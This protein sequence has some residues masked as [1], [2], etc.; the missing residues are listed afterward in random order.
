MQ[1]ALNS[2]ITLSISDPNVLKTIANSL[3]YFFRV[4]IV[5]KKDGIRL[6]RPFF[7]ISLISPPFSA[8][9]W[10]M[11]EGSSSGMGS[12]IY[13][14]SFFPSGFFSSSFFSPPSNYPTPN[15]SFTCFGKSNFA[16]HFSYVFLNLTPGFPG[17]TNTESFS[18]I[19]YFCSL[20]N[21][22]LFS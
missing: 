13:G 10:A 2:V 1:N 3:F 21:A 7:N 12:V 15:I 11:D 17:L 18:A 16:K 14:K 22:A 9:S 6:Y 4:L 5:A 19:F 20:L 8:Y